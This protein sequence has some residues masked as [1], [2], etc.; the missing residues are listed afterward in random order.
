MCGEC[1]GPFTKIQRD[2]IHPLAKAHTHAQMKAI[3]VKIK[4]V[5]SAAFDVGLFR[6]RKKNQKHEQ[7]EDWVV[8][9]K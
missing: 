1:V 2:A 3:G 9:C 8:F 5:Y 7:I 6:L 4:V